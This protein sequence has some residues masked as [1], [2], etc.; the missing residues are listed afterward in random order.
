MRLHYQINKRYLTTGTRQLC[1]PMTRTGT[2]RSSPDVK[3]P[4]QRPRYLNPQ[5]VNSAPARLAYC[6]ALHHLNKGGNSTWITS[7]C[8]A[9][10]NR[11]GVG[12]IYGC[13]SLRRS[14]FITHWFYRFFLLQNIIYPNEQYVHPIPIRSFE[15][16]FR[17][18]NNKEL[19]G[20]I[21]GTIG[22]QIFNIWTKQQTSENRSFR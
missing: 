5:Q 21:Q 19:I 10:G 16:E 17:I 7:P 20:I 14:L 9:K 15:S 6:C 3:R 4:H 8:A 11:P 2:N 1:E 18:I 22:I 12:L 13:D